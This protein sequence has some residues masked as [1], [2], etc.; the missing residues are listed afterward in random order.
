[1]SP[2][3]NIKNRKNQQL[4]LKC[5][6]KTMLKFKKRTFNIK[7]GV[8]K[9]ICRRDLIWIHI[10]NMISKINKVFERFKF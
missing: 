9:R 4:N 3:H 7:L 8:S 1:M 2:P 6:S 10:E 5:F